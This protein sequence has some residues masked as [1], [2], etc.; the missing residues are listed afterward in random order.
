LI[1]EQINFCAFKA[2]AAVLMAAK[3]E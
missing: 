3:F 2:R 1:I